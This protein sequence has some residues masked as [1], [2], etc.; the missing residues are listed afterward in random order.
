MNDYTNYLYTYNDSPIVST[1]EELGYSRADLERG[2]IPIDQRLLYAQDRQPQMRNARIFTIQGKGITALQF[3]TR[4]MRGFR[5]WALEPTGIWLKSGEQVQINLQT[6]VNISAAFGTVGMPESF[7]HPTL[8]ALN[9]GLN[10]ISAPRAG[11]LYF[12]K[13]HSGNATVEVVNGGIASP[14]YILGRHTQNDWQNMLNNLTASGVAELR[15]ER[16]Y[17]AITRSSAIKY[18]N[19]KDPANFLREL[20]KVIDFQDEVSGVY[21]SAPDERDRPDPFYLAYIEDTSNKLFMYAFHHRTGYS[22]VDGIQFVLNADKFPQGGWG[23]WHEQGHMRQIRAWM[24]NSNL[25]EITVNIYS[26]YTQRKYGQQSRLE[27]EN[28]WTKT[29]FPYLNRVTKNYD[30]ETNHFMKLGLFWQLDLAFG[31]N[32]YP[33]LHRMY[34]ALPS[35][36]VF[37]NNSGESGKQQFIYMASLCAN[38]NLAPFFEKWGVIPSANTRTRINQFPPLEKQI[39]NGRDTAPIVEYIIPDIGG[40]APVSPPVIPPVTPPVIPPPTIPPTLEHPT[41]LT[42]VNSTETSLVL[43]WNPP[44]DIS[45]IKSYEIFRAGTEIGEVPVNIHTF[46]DSGLTPNTN[47]SY[48]IRSHALSDFSNSAS[49]TTQQQPVS[50]PPPQAGLSYRITGEGTNRQS[51]IITNRSGSAISSNWALQFDFTGAA[52]SVEWPAAWTNPS[53]GRVSTTVNGALNNN[54]FATIPM[55]VGANTRISNIMVNG[56]LVNRE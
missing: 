24:W 2:H 25:V 36:E 22:G 38:R 45:K 48:T 8:R 54:S 1:P 52:P 49:G 9:P 55:N 12:T 27:A 5:F 28:E 43:S 46:T 13:E 31:K 40:E 34:R 29:I 51:L 44:V 53:G 19:G 56:A 10:T 37:A 42:V 23:P 15:T 50:P 16:T 47:Y 3:S 41:N 4:Q 11:L 35:N 39:W 14:L 33:K 7:D 17:V 20:D 32:F 26:L 18:L 21:S 6:N 30:S